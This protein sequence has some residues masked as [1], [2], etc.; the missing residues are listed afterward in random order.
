MQSTDR[1]VYP[2]K[3]GEVEN[4]QLWDLKE[5]AP[6]QSKGAKTLANWAGDPGWSQFPGCI[7]G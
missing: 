5:S 4:E 3:S 7:E 1:K 2:G 6:V